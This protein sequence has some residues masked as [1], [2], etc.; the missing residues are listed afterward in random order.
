MSDIGAVPKIIYEVIQKHR[1][2][3]PDRPVL[4]GVAGAQGS[5]KTTACQLLEATNRPRYANF[6]IDDVYLD[7][8]QR[9]DLAARTHPLFVTRGPPG[10][11]DIALARETIASLMRATPESERPIPRFDKIA[12]KMK[13]R[14]DWP[15]F[16][17]RPEAILVDAWCLGALPVPASPP[18]NTVE[19][20]DTNGQW[21][22]IQNQFLRTSYAE[23]FAEFDAIVY[24]QAPS[25]DIVRR[26][27]GQQE[28]TL[29]GR[30]LTP[31]EEAWIDRFIQHYERITRSM[32]AGNMI[33]DTVV[34]LSESR[35]PI[36]TRAVMTSLTQRMLMAV[37][38]APFAG[39][40]FG[41][42]VWSIGFALVTEASPPSLVLLLMLPIYGFAYGVSV[43]PWAMILLGIPAHFLLKKT[44]I[45]GLWAYT[46]AGILIGALV[47]FLVMGSM[48]VWS[49]ALY[50]W[51][52]AFDDAVRTMP[53]GAWLGLCIAV[54]AWLIRRPDRD[55]ANPP[56]P[57]P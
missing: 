18:L 20:E 40:F 53:L 46:L 42:V 38:V 33:A 54:I 24:L 3:H 27:R 15:V 51:S 57:L 39:C 7:T 41:L 14:G 55:A 4:I 10:T 36:G 8:Q 21:R 48:S 45:H 43:G 31:E 2:L 11:H 35:A 49:R 13:P 1:A 50:P 9:A 6:S 25:W 12:D 32:I 16:K 5:G 47:P 44:G 34:H 26:W 30:P 22:E 52:R 28:V 17:G 37:F 19:E 29:R 56:T 23:W